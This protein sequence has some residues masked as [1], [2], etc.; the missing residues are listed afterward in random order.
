[1]KVLLKDGCLYIQLNLLVRFVNLFLVIS[2]ISMLSSPNDQ[3]PANLEAAKDFRENYSEFKKR[4]RLLVR[5][6]LESL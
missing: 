3:S 6:S 4:I 2:V 5:K 1:M